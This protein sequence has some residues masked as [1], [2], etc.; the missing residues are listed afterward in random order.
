MIASA[1]AYGSEHVPCA[2]RC[3]GATVAK[4]SP[5]DLGDQWHSLHFYNCDVIILEKQQR[6]VLR[7]LQQAAPDLFKPSL[8]TF[9]TGNF[10]RM[11]RDGS[12]A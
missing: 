8:V 5:S 11:L 4:P 2:L 1:R 6:E 7:Q 12:A 10:I 9:T 3:A